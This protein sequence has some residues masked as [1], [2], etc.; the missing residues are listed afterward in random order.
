MANII[1]KRVIFVSEICQS[2]SSRLL[3]CL[4]GGYRNPKDCSRCV[5]PSGFGGQKCETF[6]PPTFLLN[7]AMPSSSTQCGGILHVGRET[8]KIGHTFFNKFGIGE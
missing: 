1:V 8:L 6:Q 4:H 2:Q 7:S 5:C 3:F